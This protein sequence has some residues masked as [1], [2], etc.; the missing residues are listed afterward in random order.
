MIGDFSTP[1]ATALALCRHM[2]V[3]L[4]RKDH[5]LIQIRNKQKR[6]NTKNYPNKKLLTIRNQRLPPF[7]RQSEALAVKK[8]KLSLL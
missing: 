5:T 7:T 3:F 8:C 1:V 4:N 6:A 2:S